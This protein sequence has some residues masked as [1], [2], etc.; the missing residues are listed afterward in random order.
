[1]KKMQGNKECF[2]STMQVALS[3]SPLVCNDMYLIRSESVDLKKRN[4]PD[5]SRSILFT[6]RLS[7]L[8]RK[9]GSSLLQAVQHHQAT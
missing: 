8:A 5:K 2:A 6:V 3:T 7:A 9:A 4:K 1:M